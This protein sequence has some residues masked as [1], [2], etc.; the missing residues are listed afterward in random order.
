MHASLNGVRL[1]KI[2]SIRTI[3]IT[4]GV[5]QHTVRILGWPLPELEDQLKLNKQALLI[6]SDKEIEGRIV[7]F[8]GD[9]HHGYEVTI[10]E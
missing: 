1:S 4:P 3:E 6:L 8:N 2:S 5:K 7:G 9:L 10:E